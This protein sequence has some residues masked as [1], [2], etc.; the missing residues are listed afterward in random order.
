MNKTDIMLV[1][2]ISVRHYVYQSV[3]YVNIN[4]IDIM[5]TGEISVTQIDISVTLDTKSVLQ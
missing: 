5:L 2:Q 3:L 1:K 4:K